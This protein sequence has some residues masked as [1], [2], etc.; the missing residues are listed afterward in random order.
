MSDMIV[1]EARVKNGRRK[2][3][4]ERRSEGGSMVEIGVGGMSVDVGVI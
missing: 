1:V 4:K 2:K 3:K